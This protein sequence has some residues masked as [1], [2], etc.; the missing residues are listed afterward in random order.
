V[1]KDIGIYLRPFLELQSD[2][3]GVY[4]TGIESITSYDKIQTSVRDAYL[5]SKRISER[6]G[7]QNT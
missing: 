2:P 4:Y 6:I 7:V 3:E 1:K 5:L